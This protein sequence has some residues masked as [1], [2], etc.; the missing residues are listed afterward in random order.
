[1]Q[2]F[3]AGQAVNIN[4]FGPLAPTQ[5]NVPVQVCNWAVTIWNCAKF[6]E[7]YGRYK[8][9]YCGEK[10]LLWAIEPLKAVKV[11]EEKDFRLA[12]ALLRAKS[13]QSVA[14]APHYWS[15]QH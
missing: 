3:H 5:Q 10:R 8:G 14:E 15:V 12:E 6:A 13:V 7:L 4:P 11:S 1:M 9:G 2:T